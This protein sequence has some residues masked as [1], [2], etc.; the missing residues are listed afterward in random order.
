MKLSGLLGCDAVL[1]FR[2]ISQ[3]QSTIYSRIP[4]AVGLRVYILNDISNFC[5][6]DVLKVN[7]IKM[8]VFEMYKLVIYV[9]HYLYSV[10]IDT[11]N[12]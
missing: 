10:C 5:K 3:R 2:W 9:H 12:L 1:S 4:N 6:I 8:P 11:R 7:Y